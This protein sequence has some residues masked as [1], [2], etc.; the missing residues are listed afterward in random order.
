MGR[1]LLVPAFFLSSLGNQGPFLVPL[2]LVLACC[3]FL[4]SPRLGSPFPLSWESGT[5]LG[6]AMTL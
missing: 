1:S 4:P 3:S 5:F 6:L 2:D